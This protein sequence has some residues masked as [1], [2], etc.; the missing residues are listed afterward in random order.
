MKIIEESKE[1]DRYHQVADLHRLTITPYCDSC[2]G[3][4]MEKPLRALPEGPAL[5]VAQAAVRVCM[6]SV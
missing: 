3:C 4:G 2:A 5:G 6:Q 1:A